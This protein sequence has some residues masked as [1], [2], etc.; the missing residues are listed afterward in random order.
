[1]PFLSIVIPV[2]N[3]GVYL[4]KCIQ[5]IMNQSFTDWELI[6][7]NDGST[8]RSREICEQWAR[9]DARIHLSHQKNAGASAARNAGIS[10]AS[11][12]YIQFTDADDWWEPE[13]LTT[14]LSE[15]KSRKE[16]ELFIFALTKIH[17]DRTCEI[18]QPRQVGDFDNF[19]FMNKLLHEQTATGAYGCVANKFI[20]KRLI[21]KLNLRFNTEYTLME[22]F[23][24]FLR[25]YAYAECISQSQTTGYSY[26]QAAENSTTRKTFIINY[27]QVM[28]IRVDAYQAVERACGT[29]NANRIWLANELNSHFLAAFIELREITL[30]RIKQLYSECLLLLPPT[31][32]YAPRGTSINSKIVSYLLSCKFLTLLYCYLKLRRFLRSC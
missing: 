9:R 23:D 17:G 29:Q 1:M 3:K 5:S 27:P 24:F 22:D 25:A 30:Q 2:Y 32:E 4:D 18:V 21:D 13:A 31:F 11:G 15:L 7:V 10:R 19:S 14:L 8:D 6:L 20:S 26:L 16:P 28:R 12:K